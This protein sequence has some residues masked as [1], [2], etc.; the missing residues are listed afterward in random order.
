MTVDV[1]MTWIQCVCPMVMS[2]LEQAACF[3]FLNRG[4]GDMTFTV[5]LVDLCTKQRLLQ[6]SILYIQKICNAAEVFG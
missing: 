3:C 1:P 2:H 6:K 4:L 5:G